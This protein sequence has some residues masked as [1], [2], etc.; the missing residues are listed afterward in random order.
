[1]RDGGEDHD[2]ED[3]KPVDWL[4]WAQSIGIMLALVGLAAWV[5]APGPLTKGW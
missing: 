1:M 5:V 4:S 3:R 2:R